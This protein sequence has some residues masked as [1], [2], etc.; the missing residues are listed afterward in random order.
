M[1][2]DAGL[3]IVPFAT[4]GM[5]EMNRKGTWL[6]K[7]SKITLYVGAPIETVGLSNDEMLAI[8]ARTHKLISD[9]AEHGIIPAAEPLAS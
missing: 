9:F 4:R 7:P 3:P 8:I 2:R 6:F 1:A 5:F